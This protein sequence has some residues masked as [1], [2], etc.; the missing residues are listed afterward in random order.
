MKTA[1][2]VLTSSYYHILDDAS[3]QGVQILF[4]TDS[5]VKTEEPNLKGKCTR[6]IIKN[7]GMP[8]RPEDWAR[9]KSIA[10]GN[11]GRQAYVRLRAY[12]SFF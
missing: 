3:A 9:L 11:P 5:P 4:T 1:S 10:E 12:V 8:F 2:T 7:N 6:L